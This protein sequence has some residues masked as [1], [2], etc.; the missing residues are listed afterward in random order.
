MK[1]TTEQIMAQRMLAYRGKGYSVLYVLRRSAWRY[2]LLVG[3]LVLS[4]IAFLSTHDLTVKGFCLWAGGMFLGALCR[5]VGWLQRIKR[6]WQFTQKIT[7]WQKVKQIAEGKE[8][9]N[10]ASEVTARKLAEPQG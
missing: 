4:M 7:D 6:S 3:L 8:A 10:Q 2:A 5:D 9:A 1:K